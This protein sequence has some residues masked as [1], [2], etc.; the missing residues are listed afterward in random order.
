ML[1][2]RVAAFRDGAHGASVAGIASKT[3]IPPW[4][5]LPRD[6]GAYAI[7]VVGVGPGVTDDISLTDI[8]VTKEMSS[9]TPGP[10]PTPTRNRTMSS[11]RSRPFGAISSPASASASRPTS[12]TPPKQQRMRR[13]R[14]TDLERGEW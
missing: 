6:E 1:A 13:D 11:T 5:A 12:Y 4:R 8:E 14:R 3:A 10:I 2:I 7:A 9:I